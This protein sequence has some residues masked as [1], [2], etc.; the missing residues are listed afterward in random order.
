MS[1]MSLNEVVSLVCEFGVVVNEVFGGDG[2][3]D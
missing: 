2:W 3:A 1:L